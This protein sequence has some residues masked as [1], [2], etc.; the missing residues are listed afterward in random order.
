MT[1]SMTRSCMSSCNEYHQKTSD[2]YSGRNIQNKSREAPCYCFVLDCTCML[3]TRHYEK[4][5]CAVRFINMRM[6]FKWRHTS[7]FQDIR[8]FS[9]MAC[10]NITRNIVRKQ[11]EHTVKGITTAPIW[12]IKTKCPCKSTWAEL[13]SFIHALWLSYCDFHRDSFIL[14]GFYHAFDCA[15]VGGTNNV[16]NL[17]VKSIQYQ[18]EQILWYITER[19]RITTSRHR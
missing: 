10:G 17:T 2:H 1:R 14:E 4:T 16:F 9:R 13:M 8:I 11:H 18:R 5:Q 7:W 19:Q 3:D 12:K 6:C 15:V